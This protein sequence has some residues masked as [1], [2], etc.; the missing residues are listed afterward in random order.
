MSTAPKKAY[1]QFTETLG[2]K[3]PKEF[4]ELSA[5]DLS[6]LNRLLAESVQRSTR[7]SRS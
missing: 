3:P 2:A 6:T 5:A 4:N 7:C 1:V